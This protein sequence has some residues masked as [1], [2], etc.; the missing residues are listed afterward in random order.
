MKPNYTKK[1]ID[2]CTDLAQNALILL[3]NKGLKVGIAESCTG[4]L[5]SYH[6]TALDGASAVLDGAMITYANAIKASWLGVSEE[7]L[8][9]YG[10]VSEP[11]V[12]EMCAGILFQSNANIA[13]ATSGIAGPSGGSVQ[14]PIGSVYIGVQ[15]KGEQAQ[16]EYCHFQG[17]RHL[18]QF[19]SCAKAL[20]MLIAL[21]HCS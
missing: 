16:I 13:L 15:R 12:R 4:G 8:K 2:I 6:F 1:S 3:Q 18:V 9:L 17:D 19:Q 5:L 7:N 11:V 10:A 14:K 21:L 20:E